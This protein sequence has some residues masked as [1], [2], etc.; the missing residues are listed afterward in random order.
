M[1]AEGLPLPGN[2]PEA[3][4]VRRFRGQPLRFSIEKLA[5]GRFVLIDWAFGLMLPRGIGLRIEQDQVLTFLKAYIR[6]HG[7]VNVLALPPTL[8]IPPSWPGGIKPEERQGWLAEQRQIHKAFARLGVLI[9]TRKLEG[10]ALATDPDFLRARRFAEELLT[11]ALR[12]VGV[13]PYPL[14]GL[15]G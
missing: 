6:V 14:V 8:A 15:L 9:R 1:A 4:L 10:K 13:E 3:T 11:A 2:V 7:D 5:D 12:S